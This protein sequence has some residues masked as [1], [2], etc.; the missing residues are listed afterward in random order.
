MFQIVL[1]RPGLTDF[2]LQHR[3]QGSLNLPLCTE[4]EL[5]IDA[6][7][8][9]LRDSGIEVLYAAPT[10]PAR[11]TA[12][13]LG[14]ALGIPV[15][16]LDGLS[17][18]DLGLWQGLTIEEIR[19]KYP[20]VY[21]QWKDSPDSVCPP[22]GEDNTDALQ[23]AMKALGKPLK[24]KISFGLVVCEPLATLLSCALRQAKHELPVAFRCS[25]RAPL[26]EELLVESIAGGVK[27]TA[28]PHG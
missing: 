1:I 21:K 18:C 16:E 13:R 14:E 28:V 15:K 5:E 2:D 27:A 4:G 11:S 12:E 17:N 23:R 25:E 20:K 3:I 6:L 7:I 10:D 24:R 8:E 9:P 19:R 26:V 22:G